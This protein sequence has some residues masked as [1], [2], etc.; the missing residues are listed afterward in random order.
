MKLSKLPLYR[1]LLVQDKEISLKSQVL[2]FI[3]IS[4]GNKIV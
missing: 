3:I 2:F 4:L 1:L